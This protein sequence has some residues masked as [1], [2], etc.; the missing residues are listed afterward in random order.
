[1]HICHRVVILGQWAWLPVERLLVFMHVVACF[2]SARVDVLLAWLPAHAQLHGLVGCRIEGL[3]DDLLARPG[4]RVLRLQQAGLR[5]EIHV[6]SCLATALV[7]SV[8]LSYGKVHSY[9]AVCWSLHCPC[10]HRCRVLESAW[11]E[12]PAESRL[13]PV[14]EMSAVRD[15]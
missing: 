8:C 9:S 6:V 5:D 3:G 2:A 11:A 1:M 13:L 10:H 15:R 12:V 7:R 4:G 14:A